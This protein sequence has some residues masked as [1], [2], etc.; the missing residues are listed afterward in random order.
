MDRRKRQEI[1]QISR[2]ID[3]LENTLELVKTS[4]VLCFTTMDRSAEETVSVEFQSIFD[5]GNPEKNKI[6]LESKKMMTDYLTEK[7]EELEKKIDII[8][9]KIDE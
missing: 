3:L 2:E 7:I 5:G 9:G 8:A 4:T 1:S 6:L